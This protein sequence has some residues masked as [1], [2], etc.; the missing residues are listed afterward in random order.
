MTLDH[1]SSLTC[2]TDEDCP[3][4]GLCGHDAGSPVGYCYGRCTF[5]EG[6]KQSFCA[7]VADEDCAQ[8]TC[9]AETGTCSIS[10]KVCDVNGDGCRKTRCVDFGDKG[11]CLVGQNCKPLEGLTCADVGPQ[12]R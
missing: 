1:R 10:K 6:A 12:Q 8:D 2:N 4:H 9:V 7:C 5:H 3:N 11:G